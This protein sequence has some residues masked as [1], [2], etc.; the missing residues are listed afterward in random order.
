MAYKMDVQVPS[1]GSLSQTTPKH[2]LDTKPLPTAS[3]HTSKDQGRAVHIKREE[4]E[5]YS[6]ASHDQSQESIEMQKERDEQMKAAKDLMP[7]SQDWAQDENK[8]FELMF[9]RQDIPLLPSHWALDFQGVPVSD[10][11][12]NISDEHSPVIHARSGQDFRG[13]AA[14]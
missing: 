6:F 8:L 3:D 4:A 1:N 12:F 10:S 7:G 5:D 13:K 14:P 2:I 11:I 9:Q